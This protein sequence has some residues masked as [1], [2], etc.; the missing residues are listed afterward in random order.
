MRLVKYSLIIFFFAAAGLLIY[1]WKI[2]PR[3]LRIRNVEVR[4]SLIK[5]DSRIIFLADL[6]IPL[7]EKLE[8]KIVE[9]LDKNK[10]DIILVGGDFSAYRV[11]AP[12]AAEKLKLLSLYGKVVMT[13]GNTDMCGSRQCVYCALKYPVDRLKDFPATILRNEQFRLP[14]NNISIFGL[15][16]PITRHNDTLFFKSIHEAEYNILLTHSIYSLAE[17]QKQRFNLIC[18]GHTHGGQIF[19]L[20]PFLHFFDKMI[21]NKYI[22]GFF[23][24]KKGTMIVTKGIG[25]SFLPLRC[26][27]VPEIIIIDLKKP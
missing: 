3:M 26:G 4:S 7:P 1:S 24:L 17:Y 14:D 8:R 2:E 15:D 22:S 9:T 11:R 13:L 27:V 6:H 18:S 20:K 12:Y 5:K 16:D 23:P 25:T 10:P 19:F 21:D